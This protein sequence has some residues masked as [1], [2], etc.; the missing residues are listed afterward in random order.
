MDHSNFLIIRTSF[1]INSYNVDIS[2]YSPGI[3]SSFRIMNNLNDSID[4]QVRAKKYPNTNFVICLQRGE[5]KQNMVS[6]L[7]WHFSF[8]CGC[9]DLQIIL[10]LFLFSFIDFL[11]FSRIM[12][13]FLKA[14][15]NIL[16]ISSKYFISYRA[17]VNK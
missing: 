8:P 15:A 11:L 9:T 16:C 1:P 13:W 14:L 7:G 10:K 6:V 5:T 4:T 17:H 3:K 12:P 2:P